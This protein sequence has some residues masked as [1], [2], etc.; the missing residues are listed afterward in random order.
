[1][2]A[3]AEKASPLEL[4]VR[5]LDEGF[6]SFLFVPVRLVFSGCSPLRWQPLKASRTYR[7]IEYL[8][9]FS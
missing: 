8:P 5:T 2:A 9:L 6:D 1:M 7:F 4:A 3:R